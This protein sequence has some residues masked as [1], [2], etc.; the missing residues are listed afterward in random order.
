MADTNC[1]GPFIPYL[2]P[3]EPLAD[4]LPSSGEE[5]L[6]HFEGTV[7]GDHDVDRAFSGDTVNVKVEVRLPMLGRRVSG[8]PSFEV[9]EAKLDWSWG[10][11]SSFDDEDEP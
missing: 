10:A 9:T 7:Q 3:A 6:L 4:P 8:A 1:A 5:I 2:E 11:G